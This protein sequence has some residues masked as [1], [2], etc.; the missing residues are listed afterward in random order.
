MRKRNRLNE[1]VHDIYKELYFNATPS[2]DFDEVVR[3]AKIENGQ[4][5]IPY[6][7][8]EIEDDLMT[9]IINKHTKMNK[10]SR[11]EKASIRFEVLLGVSPRSKLVEYE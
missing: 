6:M 5:I 1:I 4:K 10:L 9:K 8:Y 3:N 11:R 7:D 2:A